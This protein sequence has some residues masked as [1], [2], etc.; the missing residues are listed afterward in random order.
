MSADELVAP[1]RISGSTSLVGVI[2]WPVGGSLSPAIHNAAFRALGLDWVYVPLAVPPGALAEAVAGL[3]ALGFAGANVTMPHKAEAAAA[4]EDLSEDAERLGAVNTIVIGPEGS[5]GH[6]TDVTGFDRFLREDAG[7]EPAGRTAVLFGAGGAARACALALARGG[8]SRLVVAARDPER[9]AALGRAV[10]DLV[11]AE[12]TSWD[13]REGDLDPDL[14]VNATPVGGAGEELPLP[15]LG[16]ATV[17]VDLLYRPATTPLLAAARGAGAR[18]FG[19]LGT[20]LRQGALSFELWT[21]LV[22]PLEV[23]SAA[24]VAALA[25]SPSDTDLDAARRARDRP[26]A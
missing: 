13:L 22:P 23:M 5:S 8:V 6:N 17:V 20:L 14:V 4:L 21:G 7:F 3:R 26:T 9:G 24:A 2:G 10:E 19:G 1:S 12:V 11:D 25:E 18:A 15:A 16:E